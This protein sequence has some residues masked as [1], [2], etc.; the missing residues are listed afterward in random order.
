MATLP[1]LK[2]VQLICA[3]GSYGSSINCKRSGA[4]VA[5]VLRPPLVKLVRQLKKSEQRNPVLHFAHTPQEFVF[6]SNCGGKI[7]SADLR[8]GAEIVV[9]QYLETNT[10]PLKREI[11]K[12]SAYF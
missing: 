3:G 11:E 7:R 12:A 2:C 5:V 6:Q 8:G 4:S 9:T 10:S 1:R